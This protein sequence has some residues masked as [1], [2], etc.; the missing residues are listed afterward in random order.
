MEERKSQLL[1]KGHNDAVIEPTE[2]A[3]RNDF[4]MTQL[5]PENFPTEQSLIKIMGHGHLGAVLLPVTDDNYEQPQ[6]N[7]RPGEKTQG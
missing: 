2:G 3:V 1:L 5:D 4:L 7:F 6:L